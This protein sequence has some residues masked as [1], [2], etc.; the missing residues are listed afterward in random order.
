MDLCRPMRVASINR[1]KYI[2]VIVDDY[3]RN[4]HT[5][6]GTEFVNQTLQ[7]YYEQVGI[8]HE[9]SVARTPQQNGVVE[10]YAPKKKAY[11]IYNRCTRKIIE[12]T[13]VDFDELTAMASEQL[14]SGPGLQCMTPATSSSG[15]IPN[16]IPQKPPDSPVSTSIYQDAPSTSIPS[17]QE[18]EHSSI[19]SQGFEESPKTPHFHDDP[20]YESLHEDSTS[21]G[22][23]SNVRPIHTSFE[24]LGRWTKDHPIANVIGD[25]SRSVSSKKQLQTDAIWC[26]FDAFLTSVEP[27][28]FKQAMQDE[29]IDFEESF[30]PVARIEAI[31]IFVANAVNK[32]ITIFQMDVKTTFLNGELKQEVYVSQPEGFVDQDNPSHVYK[33]KKALYGL[34]Q[35]PRA[36]YGMLSSFLISLHF[37]KGAVDPTLF[38]RKAG[39]ELL[40]VQNYVDDIIFASTN[41][42]MCNEFAN[43]MTTKFKMSMMGQMSFFLGLQISQSPKGIFLNQ[44]KYASEIIKIFG[45]LTS[46][47][48]DTPMVEK[49]KLDED[50]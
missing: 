4:I 6:I 38:T 37:S 34:K 1:K 23:S 12:T 3:S 39:N 33:L 14:G 45:M 19:I 20:L 2:L 24:S 18:Q 9:T 42:T 36:W 16:L 46:D 11:R 35:A 49:S 13:H 31:R 28:N 29:G 8:S 27:N 32:N 22:S 50:L 43:P 15:L 7:D 30:T 10:R 25:P 44:S 21:Q 47:S 40:P 5:D 26:Y 41:T 17:S 48:V